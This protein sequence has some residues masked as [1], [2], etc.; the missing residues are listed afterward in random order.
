MIVY[1]DT[2]AIIKLLIDEPGTPVV[3]KL[4]TSADRRVTCAL[5]LVEARAAL[6][7]ARRANRLSAAGLKRAR[8]EL[9][10]LLD[11]AVEVLIDDDLVETAC[12]LAESEA[13]RGYDAV[14][15]AAAVRIEATVFVTADGDLV[16]AADHRGLHVVDPINT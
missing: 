16:A 9:A 5:T 15:L 11:Q 3:Q 13:L 6:A 1:F 12:E 14:H 4:W 2:S 10:G 8:A 7:A